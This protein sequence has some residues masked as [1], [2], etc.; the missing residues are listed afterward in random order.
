MIRIFLEIKRDIIR[1]RLHRTGLS[2]G[3]AQG[4]I[5]RE[6]G[7][8]LLGG[9]PCIQVYM[10][11]D[12]KRWSSVAEVQT[13]RAGF[14]VWIGCGV[15]LGYLSPIYLGSI[16]GIGQIFSSVSQNIARADTGIAGGFGHRVASRLGSL[17]LPG[18]LAVG[19]GCG[20]ALGY[21]F[22]IGVM[23]KPGVF[24]GIFSPKLIESLSRGE[25]DGWA[26]PL[27]GSHGNHHHQQFEERLQSLE[28]RI[29]ALESKSL[30]SGS[31]PADYT[32]ELKK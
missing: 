21:G 18:G 29:A 11:F 22:G 10:V 12:V 8:S 30:P 6:K 15:G 23:V 17:K 4:S 1:S 27:I 2:F 26:P 24:K 13:G 31:A 16:P 3:C 7:T 19:S 14:G 9:F 32:V 5:L 28:G 20:C 25:G